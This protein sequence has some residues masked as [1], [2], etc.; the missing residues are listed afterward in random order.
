MT[1]AKD[2]CSIILTSAKNLQY[3]VKYVYT[4]CVGIY[5]RQKLFLLKFDYIT[6][7]VWKHLSNWIES[8][9]ESEI[10]T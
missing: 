3:K 9:N 6:V 1:N 2:R 10:P 7:S 8:L 5:S 4:P